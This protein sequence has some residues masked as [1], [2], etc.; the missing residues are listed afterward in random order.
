MWGAWAGARLLVAVA[1]AL[2]GCRNADSK[3]EASFEDRLLRAELIGFSDTFSAVVGGAMDDIAAESKDRSV[4]EQTLRFKLR[5]I[6]TMQDIVGARNARY[7]FLNAYMLCVYLV[8]YLRDGDGQGIFAE[9]QALALQTLE[10][11]R[12]DVEAIGRRFLEAED[13]ASIQKDVG[14]LADGFPLRGR[15][16]A[17]LMEAARQ[18]EKSGVGFT[19]L[20]KI[21]LGGVSEGAEAI[22]RFASVA[23][24]FT[25]VV[26]DLPERTRWQSELLILNL[27]TSELFVALRE[28]VDRLSLA[29][30]EIAK[31]GRS[32]PADVRAETEA[33]LSSLD[34]REKGLLPM[35]DELN[36]ALTRGQSLTQDMTVAGR[37]W[38]ET[39]GSVGEVLDS[40]HAFSD[41]GQTETAPQEESR[42]FDI[43]EYTQAAESIRAGSV[44]LRALLDELENAKLD[45]V[46]GAADRI[47]GSSITLAAH[48]ADDLVDRITYRALALIGALC[49][50]LCAVRVVALRLA[51]PG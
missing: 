49:V 6:P 38:N 8:R 40:I 28:D 11:M 35:L 39:A 41:D 17:D 7:A 33:L 5:S 22:D 37:V 36:H 1:L 3:P 12:D 27:E 30:E 48:E 13:F 24:V 44:E 34:D 2:G 47:S 18:A 10:Q 42:P 19:S 51:R 26:E 43:R 29:A 31:T 16:A 15:F 9:G 50:G 4:R 46:V 21:P 25:K 32:L 14:K 20:F 23:S 45:G